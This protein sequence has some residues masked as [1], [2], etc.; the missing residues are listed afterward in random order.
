MIPFKKNYHKSTLFSFVGTFFELIEMNNTNGEN[1]VVKYTYE[2]IKF[3]KEMVEEIKKSDPIYDGPNMDEI[4]DAIDAIDAEAATAVEPAYIQMINPLNKSDTSFDPNV[5]LECCVER[6]PGIGADF[7][8]DLLEP[9]AEVK[10]MN[11]QT[12]N[13]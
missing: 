11:R 8:N 2:Q 12:S 1:E 9:E 10:A 3:M 6:S 4:T 7:E 13:L 5:P